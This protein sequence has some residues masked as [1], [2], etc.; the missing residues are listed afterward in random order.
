MSKNIIKVLIVL[1]LL[2]T[3]YI[4]SVIAEAPAPTVQEMTIPELIS[5]F[6]TQYDVSYTEMYKTIECETR[7]RNIQSEIV[8]NGVREESYGYSQIHLPSH[9]DISKQEALTPSFAIEFL[10]K[11]FSKG[12]QWQW[13]CA[14]KLGFAK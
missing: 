13:T 2:F 4:R 8:K 11:E 14:R 1:A 10:A 5:L 12:R 6:S 9:P 3:I 7:F